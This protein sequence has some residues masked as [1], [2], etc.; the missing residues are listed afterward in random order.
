MERSKEIWAALQDTVLQEL[1]SQ[2]QV[3]GL[4]DQDLDNL[5]DSV[6]DVVVA[7]FEVTPRSRR[8]N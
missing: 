3:E 4:T 5:A 7:A 8:R 2:V 6:A 1:R